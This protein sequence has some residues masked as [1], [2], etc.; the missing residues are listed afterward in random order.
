MAANR[1]ASGL[2]RCPEKKNQASSQGVAVTLLWGSV[3]SLTQ[4]FAKQPRTF[5]LTFMA[6]ENYSH[7]LNWL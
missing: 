2:L 5:D 3:L 7:V 1:R 6:T 4:T